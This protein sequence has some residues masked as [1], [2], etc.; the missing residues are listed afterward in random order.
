MAERGEHQRNEFEQ[1]RDKLRQD[2]ET[3]NR[4]EIQN[5]ADF[6]D[7]VS[8]IMGQLTRLH[9]IAIGTTRL[10]DDAEVDT[11]FTQAKVR[12]KKLVNRSGDLDN[13]AK[14][15][16]VEWSEKMMFL[17]R[18][19]N[20][21]QFGGVRISDVQDKNNKKVL[22]QLRELSGRLGGGLDQD[23]ENLEVKETAAPNPR[24]YNE[25]TES[26]NNLRNSQF[27]RY[28]RS[29]DLDKLNPS[30]R[31]YY[32]ALLTSGVIGAAA[33][34]LTQS[35]GRETPLSDTAV[36]EL[37]R[38]WKKAEADVDAYEVD[39]PERAEL[40]KIQRLIDQLLHENMVLGLGDGDRQAAR[41]NGWREYLRPSRRA[42][43]DAKVQG[44]LEQF[45]GN[46]RTELMT[47]DALGYQVAD[48]VKRGEL[49][50]TV[51]SEENRDRLKAL[52]T[53]M[54]DYITDQ[55]QNVT[56][57]GNA[58]SDEDKADLQKFVAA[59][60]EYVHWL[61]RLQRA[62]TPP[63]PG[64]GGGA[65]VE[66]EDG[67][68]QPTFFAALQKYLSGAMGGVDSVPRIVTVGATESNW[69]PGLREAKDQYT[70]WLETATDFQKLLGRTVLNLWDYSFKTR[71]GATDGV[72]HIYDHVAD[73]YIKPPEIRTVI[74][75]YDLKKTAWDM[76]KIALRMLIGI[77][78]DYRRKY[79][80]GGDGSDGN[81][82]V[83]NKGTFEIDL[84]NSL[85][86]YIG[87]SREEFM[88][89]HN[90]ESEEELEVLL[91]FLWQLNIDTSIMDEAYSAMSMNGA[92]KAHN[93]KPIPHDIDG[94]KN[95]SMSHTLDIIAGAAYLAN[96]TPVTKKHYIMN[97][98]LVPLD[99]LLI[100]YNAKLPPTQRRN[101]DIDNMSD[102]EKHELYEAII[103]KA[104]K[105]VRHKEELYLR[106]LV[107]N[108]VAHE[109]FGLL[110]VLKPENH[111]GGADYPLPVQYFPNLLASILEYD[112]S[113]FTRYFEV[114]A[115]GFET[116]IF[117]LNEPLPEKVTRHKAEELIG[118]R[119]IKLGLGMAKLAKEGF[120]EEAMVAMAKFYI[121]RVF[122]ALDYGDKGSFY[123]RQ[124][125][126][127]LPTSP[128]LDSRK[129][130]INEIR[131]G[132]VREIEK[133]STTLKFFGRYANW[134][135]A[136][137][138]AD[139]YELFG[140]EVAIHA[141]SSGENEVV[142]Y[143]KEEFLDLTPAEKEQIVSAEVEAEG[144]GDIPDYLYNTINYQ[145]IE[146]YVWVLFKESH[147][148]LPFETL[149]QRWLTF[150]SR[151]SKEGLARFVVPP[152]LGSAAI[153]EEEAKH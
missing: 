129:R 52:E 71:D 147:V 151:F 153:K 82:Y 15:D 113:I 128:L 85:F 116:L 81:G 96:N 67:E 63:P 55:A 141:K 53:R 130:T 150:K 13:N 30:Q 112:Q 135:S 28:I 95:E 69:P 123:P 18:Q 105:E 89:V 43:L 37:Y 5:V 29:I 119:L 39:G 76:R 19:I 149:Q 46:F 144:F 61:N 26:L 78:P 9:E 73:N 72:E 36:G 41:E 91:N 6:R 51:I 14:R 47:A 65:D 92:S 45:L 106:A 98:A 21:A 145:E 138:R 100:A 27:L 79:V 54:N 33:A 117:I 111:P 24:D 131:A 77:H 35:G 83:V 94:L 62:T 104:V 114:E 58:L 120:P 25:T 75:H 10:D 60:Q 88:A 146:E 3:L 34:D 11:L 118:D 68:P 110:P 4:V 134:D 93:T 70:K 50:H 66:A 59:T 22:E 8:P 115:K 139:I 20:S 64:D 86:D 122:R 133:G 16:L 44:Q 148:G 97:L 107:G 102:D 80:Y 84:F 49:A 126:G 108:R 127:P 7:L 1:L 136:I 90:I 23:F 42:V 87:V 99:A 74:E 140:A 152:Y 56:M 124:A 38:E 2:L 132:L 142:S 109:L 121:S 57:F 40:R 101:L 143:S 12:I 103:P 137:F 31:D 32:D 125:F 17:T 48:A